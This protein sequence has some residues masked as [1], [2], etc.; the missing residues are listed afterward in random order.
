MNELSSWSFGDDT[1]L[2]SYLYLDSL[3]I[4]QYNFSNQHWI[5]NYFDLEGPNGIKS[6]G[7]FTYL[8]DSLLVKKASG[9]F[10][11]QLINLKNKGI[12][13]YSFENG[14]YNILNLSPYSVYFDGTIIG[15]PIRKFIPSGTPNFTQISPV[16]GF[17]NL[18]KGHFTHFI[19]FPEEFQNNS[20]SS[21]FLKHT[22][23]VTDDKIILNFRKSHFIYCY[24]LKG[25]LISKADLRI[26]GVN[27][28]NR[29]IFQYPF[30]NMTNT[31]FTGNYKNLIF[32]GEFYYRTALVYPTIGN[33][34]PNGFQE[35]QQASN[36]SLF[37]IIK[38]DRNLTPVSTGYYSGAP[39]KNGLGDG[40]YFIFNNHLYFW[41]LNSPDE[42]IG[43]FTSIQ[44]N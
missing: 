25:N 13:N 42:G 38:C 17:Y 4:F 39:S 7:P 36:S 22:F 9:Q 1:F 35:I 29:G 5:T 26:R 12:K 24:D 23:L 19:Y 32:D 20:C 10:G 27:I 44:I 33:S 40:R 18:N 16:Y 28:E 21:N 37:K 11:F 31:E 3:G 41:H 43:N 14:E 2:Y 15:L 8:N 30:Q 6:T 34:L